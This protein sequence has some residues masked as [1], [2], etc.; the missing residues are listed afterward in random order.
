MYLINCILII[1]GV[2]NIFSPLQQDDYAKY[3]AIVK[4][5]K[6]TTWSENNSN[7]IIIMAATDK[8]DFEKMQKYFSNLQTDNPR[9]K[10]TKL[11]SLD[12]TANVHVIYIS[13]T[14][15]IT[16][17]EIK[18]KITNQQILSLTTDKNLLNYGIMFYFNATDNCTD[19][20]YNRQAVI[21]SGL[22][23]RSSLLNYTHQYTIN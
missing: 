15:Q 23:I 18:E 10:L 12:E 22:T 17:T 5:I 21:E 20:L 6:Y 8:D 16:P 7:E 3:Q 4:F 11:N 13:E 9:I 14:A 1:F 19:Y 2:I